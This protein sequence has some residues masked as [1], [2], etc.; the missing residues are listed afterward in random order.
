MRDREGEREIRGERAGK[1]T[2]RGEE[3]R[4][5][6]EGAL[7]G[8]RGERLWSSLARGIPVPLRWF[9]FGRSAEA[10][11]DSLLF[12][13]CV[14]VRACFCV[15]VRLLGSYLPAASGHFLLVAFLFPAQFP[16]LGL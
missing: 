6:R 4:R 16:F 10:E 9:I 1:R 12:R 7:W 3:E 13:V 8:S 5:E 14:R 2:G 11:E 15:Y